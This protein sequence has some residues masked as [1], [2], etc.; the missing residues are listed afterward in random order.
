MRTQRITTAGPLIVLAACASLAQAAEPPPAAPVPEKIEIT[1]GNFQPTWD[2]LKQYECPDWFRDAK[3]GIWACWSPQC[4]PEQGDWYARNMY[5]EGSAHYQFHVKTYGHPSKFGYKDII[6]LWKGERWEPERMMELYKRA[7]AKYFTFMVNHHCNFDAWDSKYQQWNSV[8]LGPH[9]DITGLYAAAARKCG[10]RFGVTVHNARSWDWYDVAHKSDTKGPLAGVPYDGALT[11][12]DGKGQWWEGY[13]PADLYGPHGAARTPEAREN[14]V[15]KWFYRTR[16]LLDKYRPDLLY[17]DDGDLPLGD[18]GKSIAAHFY[19]ANMQWH[20]GKLEAV[21]NI[22]GPPPG[23]RKAIVLDL[24]RGLADKLEQFPWQTDTC[25]GDWHYRRGIHYKSAGTVVAM[26]ADIVSK[27]GNLLLNIP[28]RGDGSLDDEEVK[29]LEEMAAWMDVNSES[30]FATRPWKVYGEGRAQKKGGHFNEGGLRYS[31]QDIRFTVGQFA[32]LPNAKG[33][34][35]YAIALGWPE[36]RKLIVRSLA[37]AKDAPA[38]RIEGVSLLGCAARLDWSRT[39]EGL[40]VTLPEQKPCEHAFVLKISGRDLEPA[41]LAQESTVALAQEGKFVLRAVDAAIHGDS[42]QYE[43]GGGKDNIGYWA[44]SA[45]YV[46]WDLKLTEP[47]AYQVQVAYSCQNGAEGSE[48][49][50]SA[51]GQALTGKSSA[52]GSWATFTTEKLGML[53]LDKAGTVT[54]CV[55]PKTPPQWKVIGLQAVTLRAEKAER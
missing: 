49:T 35:L 6:A 45:D 43:S 53:K 8:N 34:I 27:N 14:Y 31:A 55:K 22:K 42:P 37:E 1:T 29:F 50:V 48:Y 30:I 41:P 19:N 4:V 33:E 12:S 10:L 13:D 46:S 25:I 5:M 26:L 39:G 40:V 18:A 2:S 51:G 24:E 47:G 3:F 36:N 32:K 7:G 38:G 11:K 23:C 17:F 28:V 16:D 54:L 52:T 21:L 20:D 9:K 15:R 44:N